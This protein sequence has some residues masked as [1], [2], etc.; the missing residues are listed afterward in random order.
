VR[1]STGA[2]EASRAPCGM[3]SA[4]LGGAGC[5]RPVLR[6]PAPCPDWKMRQGVWHAKV[7]HHQRLVAQGLPCREN[8]DVAPPTDGRMSRCRLRCRRCLLRRSSASRP[9][10]AW[11]SIPSLSL[12]HHRQQHSLWTLP[13]IPRTPPHPHVVDRG[14][15]LGGC[16]GACGP[17]PNGLGGASEE[18]QVAFAEVFPGDAMQVQVCVCR[19]PH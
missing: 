2:A 10:V 16:A 14:T 11:Y 17:A 7:P 9:T 5:D 8:A 18:G 4:G 13:L 15:L 12:G 6:A 19:F 1:A 3:Y